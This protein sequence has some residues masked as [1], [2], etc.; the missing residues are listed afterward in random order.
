MEDSQ[1]E[2]KK[3]DRSK[4]A[5]RRSST[6]MESLSEKAFGPNGEGDESISRR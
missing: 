6:K 5:K 4:D 2:I 3:Q 1:M